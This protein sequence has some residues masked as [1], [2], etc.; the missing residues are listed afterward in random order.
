MTT[1]SNEID[2]SPMLIDIN[3]VLKGHLT[4][5][6]GPMINEKNAIQN[7]LL[8]M[9]YVNNLK[10][11]NNILKN[12]IFQLKTE[13]NVLK[14]YY[15]KELENASKKNVKLEVRDSKSGTP[16]TPSKIVELK[17]QMW[18]TNTKVNSNEESVS[19]YDGLYDEE[20]EDED[21][22]EDDMSEYEECN[23]CE[24]MNNID[25]LDNGSCLNCLSDEKTEI[26][27]I[28]LKNL[29]NI[30]KIDENGMSVSF[31][32]TILNS[33]KAGEHATIDSDSDECVSA[34]TERDLM[35]L[36]KENVKED[37][38]KEEDEE[39]AAEE[40]D[41]DEEEVVEEEDEDEDEEV[42]EEEEDEEVDEEDEEVE[43]EDEEVEEEDEEVE[44]EDEEVEEEDEE[45]E[46]EDEDEDEE[47]EE[48]EDE[49]E[50]VEEDE[51]EEVEEDSIQVDNQEYDD[52]DDE[53]MEVEDVEIDGIQYLTTSP[54]DGK[55]YQCDDEG[56]MKEDENGDF[57]VCGIFKNGIANFI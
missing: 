17:Q 48:E 28:T 57:I 16:Q 3:K 26:K 42:E 25:L 52:D 54:V 34:D 19:G 41:E 1:E 15:D 56:E 13:L 40:E 44:E 10:K 20:D 8:N 12:N 2:I 24:K 4:A 43:E 7:I 29:N 33:Q 5:I 51:D 14:Q 30:T 11:E 53:D 32:E 49:D 22:D 37:E 35:E 36:T 55:I 6:L 50:E 18:R 39:E 38:E 47:I 21:E 23:R 31:C 9:P 45:V 27:N 46:E